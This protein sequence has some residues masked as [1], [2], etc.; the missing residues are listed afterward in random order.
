MKGKCES[1]VAWRGSDG[2]SEW[3]NVRGAWM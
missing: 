2:G 1:E 3:W